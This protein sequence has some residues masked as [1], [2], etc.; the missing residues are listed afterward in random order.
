VGDVPLSG[1]LARALGDLTS[2][3]AADLADPRSMPSVPMWFGLLR[4]VPVDDELAQ[5]DLPALTQLSKRAIR[6][7]VGAAVRSGWLQV[8]GGTGVGARLGL[9]SSGRA[10]ATEWRAMIAPA[11]HRWCKRVGADRDDLRKMFATIVD[12]FDLELPHYPISYGAADHSVT[13]GRFRPARPGPPRIPAH[14]QDWAPVI[15]KDA[16][17]ASGLGLTAILSQLLV[18][19]TID[20]S[21]QGGAA[22]VIAEGLVR[23][24]GTKDVAPI[25]DLPP[26]LGVSGTGRSGL[27]RHHVVSVQ[28]PT[29][30]SGIKVAQLTTIGQRVRDDYG[31]LV[32]SIERDWADRYGSSTVTT[33]RRS[34]ESLLPALDPDLPDALMASYVRS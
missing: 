21:E 30:D 20:Y 18:W 5:R 25:E 26:V 19:Y 1:L 28:T 11:E 10:A 12:Q 32:R 31:A 34:L 29:A 6:Q 23:G 27:E 15:R 14:G 4:A 2:E 22:L 9:T 13:G 33:L 8:M 24:F 17:T 16:D 3:F 7:L